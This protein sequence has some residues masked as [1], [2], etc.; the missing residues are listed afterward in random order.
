MDVCHKGKHRTL[1]CL[2]LH[3]RPLFSLYPPGAQRLVPEFQRF[4]AIHGTNIL[5]SGLTSFR[6]TIVSCTFQCRKITHRLALLVA[7]PLQPLTFHSFDPTILKN[8]TMYSVAAD[9][10]SAHCSSLS[11]P[12]WV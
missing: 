3:E 6:I 4:S 11:C 1:M 9:G 2:L 10:A 7:P 5:Q 8:T 12:F